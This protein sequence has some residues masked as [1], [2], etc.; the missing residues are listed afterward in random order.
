MGRTLAIGDEVV[1]RVIIPCPRCISVTLAQDDLPRDPRILRTVAE[2][3]MCDL[4]DFGTLPCAGVYAEVV[5][6][7]TIRSGDTVRCLD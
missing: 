5:K 6:P 7:G 4:G 1:L 2:H 3:N